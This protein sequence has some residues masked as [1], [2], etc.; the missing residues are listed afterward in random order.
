ME[1]GPVGMEALQRVCIALIIAAATSA[2][3]TP[4]LYK[5]GRYEDSIFD[6]YLEPGSVPVT[7]EIARLEADIE[8]TVSSGAFVPPGVHAH[9][10][11]LYVSEGD[12][13]TAMVHFQ[14]EKK[15]FPESAHFI[16]GLIERMNQ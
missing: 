6:M 10:G 8:K 3:A 5:W 11:Y 2:C 16:D 12:Y 14:S 7:D 4:T 13:A 15:K 1:P 9:L